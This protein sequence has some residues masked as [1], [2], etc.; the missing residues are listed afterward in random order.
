MALIL[1]AIHVLVSLFWAYL[2]T[3]G[4]FPA[5]ADTAQ[6]SNLRDSVEAKKTRRLAWSTVA[7]TLVTTIFAVITCGFLDQFQSGWLHSWYVIIVYAGGALSFVVAAGLAY[8][9]RI[10]SLQN[11]WGILLLTGVVLQ[12]LTIH[13][14]WIQ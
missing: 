11:R 9:D 7:V 10:P 13:P 6:G 5:A 2:F 12:M 4:D 1:Q 8:G 14:L 3:A